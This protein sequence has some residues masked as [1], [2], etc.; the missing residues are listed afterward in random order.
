[1]EGGTA[2]LGPVRDGSQDSPAELQVCLELP[3]P[4]IPQSQETQ[5]GA[6]DRK[7]KPDISGE[8]ET[9]ELLPFLGAVGHHELKPLAGIDIGEM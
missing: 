8:E 2:S 6:G 4:G 3:I 1:M 9:G 7:V 5:G